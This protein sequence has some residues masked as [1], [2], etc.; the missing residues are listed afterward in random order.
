MI[1]IIIDIQMNM[2]NILSMFANR[3]YLGNGAVNVAL[4]VK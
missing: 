3:L 2:S 1:D 4:S